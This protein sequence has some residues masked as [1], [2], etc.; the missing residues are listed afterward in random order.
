MKNLLLKFH[1]NKFMQKR[2]CFQKKFLYF[3]TKKILAFDCPLISDTYLN[4]IE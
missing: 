3:A 4:C 2:R 1:L